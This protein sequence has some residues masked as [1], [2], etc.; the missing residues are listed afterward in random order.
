MRLPGGAGAGGAHAS[1]QLPLLPF[2][3]SQPF[4]QTPSLPASLEWRV[5]MW[6]DTAET[7]AI[8]LEAQTQGASCSP[9]RS[10]QEQEGGCGSHHETPEGQKNTF[11]R[12]GV[13]KETG[14]EV[15]E[16]MD[17]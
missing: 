1:L 17:T 4:V 16:S 10:I 5:G 8:Y 12:A 13:R 3:D 6:Q 14:K 2:W 7:P 9:Q 11:I 15:R